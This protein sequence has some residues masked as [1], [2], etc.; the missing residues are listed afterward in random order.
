MT[1]G[2]L[3]QTRLCQKRGVVMKSWENEDAEGIWLIFHLVW[4]LKGML[5]PQRLRPGCPSYNDQLE[6]SALHT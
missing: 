4:N 1:V 6:W 5:S 3:T 2:L